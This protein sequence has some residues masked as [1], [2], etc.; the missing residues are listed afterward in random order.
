VNRLPSRF[1]R[2][3]LVA[4]LVAILPITLWLF[5]QP[6]PVAR[7]KVPAAPL[8]GGLTPEQQAA[9]ELALADLRVLA[10]TS[11]HRAEVFGVRDVGMH[12]PSGHEAC[13]AHDCRQ[14]EI[15]LYDENATVLA[16]VDL[17]AAEVREVYYQPGSQPGANQ[18]ITNL[19]AEIAR[20]S[21]E[22]IAE[23][24]Y[25]PAREDLVPMSGGLAGTT[26]EQHLCLAMNVRQGDSLIW[27]VVDMTERTM[28]GVVRA[29]VPADPD[30]APPGA[31]ADAA[32][33]AADCPDPGAVQRDGWA[34][35]YETTA[36]D[37]LRVYG[38]TYW[39]VPVL[40]SA[41]LAEWHA[42]YGLSG[43]QDEIGCTGGG[44]GYTIFP[45]GITEV[46]DVVTN[47]E[48]V[49]FELVQGFRM[50]NWG[51]QCNYRYGQHYQFYAGGAFR[52]V[53]AAY[54]KGC[55]DTSTYRM[56]LRIDL[57]I[58]GH[59]DDSF[60]IW[61]GS[62]WVTQAE[63]DWW[64]QAAPY[65]G[66]GYK[67]RISDGGGRVYFV[68]PGQGQF[69]DNGR[70]D[71]AY[72]Y[73]VRHH[74]SEGDMNLPVL[75]GCC[76]DNQEQGPHAYINGESIAGE[77]LVL[78]YVPQMETVV[79]SAPP[80]DYY[81]W[82]VSG[83]PNPETYPCPAGPKF[84]PEFAVSFQHNQPALPTPVVHFT[85]TTV[86]SG[87]LTYAWDFGDSVGASLVPT[88]T[89]PYAAPGIYTITLTASDSQLTSTVTQTVVVGLPA[90][91]NFQ[92][93]F[94]TPSANGL[95]FVNTTTG[96]PPLTYLWDFGDGMTS[97]LAAP[98]HA[99]P[100]PGPY[101]VTLTATNP[102]TSSVMTHVVVSPWRNLLPQILRP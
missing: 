7:G 56:L 63:E 52:V 94:A 57:A 89:Y 49:G 11:G 34:V 17:D 10:R 78:W 14:V 15:Y 79:D 37:G 96:T 1:A 61:D 90:A 41:K 40:T 59:E 95:D 26:C 58:A 18:R 55:D 50:S 80:T 48:V 69:G 62:A 31:L 85:S 100:L 93:K 84:V 13:T 12:F 21:P 23:L 45:F 6:A 27:A 77:N 3:G 28:V 19:A 102:L 46:H 101:T 16:L 25:R 51:A 81:C 43:F 24:G 97:T 68:E 72:I 4:A 65:T 66:E 86:G 74:A 99:Y 64:S 32:G 73:A 67:W 35:N 29:A 42:D 30:A 53:G 47:G 71:N 60:A 36:N 5:V 88:P 2:R 83:E 38:V 76:Q 9:Q 22:L 92:T 98:T 44:G 33:G 70:G 82:T 87:P 20:N 54:G 75:G 39:G 8:A 91:A